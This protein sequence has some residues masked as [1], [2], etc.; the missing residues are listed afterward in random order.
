MFAIGRRHH[1]RARIHMG[2]GNIAG[3]AVDDS[4]DA[5][6]CLRDQQMLSDV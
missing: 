2:N 1:L 6:R 5:E 3:D 4:Q